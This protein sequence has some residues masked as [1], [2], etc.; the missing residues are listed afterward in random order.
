M[1]NRQKLS[2]LIY[3]TVFLI[4]TF[5]ILTNS[6]LSLSYA[7]TGLELWYRNMIPA[8]M[9]FMILSGTLIRMGLTEG[10]TTLVYPFVRPLFRV[11]RNV[12]Y[13]MIMGF[14]CGF[15]MG[16]KCVADLYERGKLSRD[17]G[18]YLLAFC[19]NIG[20]VYFVSFALPLIGCEQIAPCLFGMYGIPL[21]YGLVLRYTRY[22]KLSASP[23]PSAS[24]EAID[25]PLSVKSPAASAS[26]QKLLG[27]LDG[28]IRNSLQSMLMLGGYMVLFN[29][30]MLL[31]HLLLGQTPQRIAPLLEITGG[32]K[33]LG[34]RLPLYSL[35]VLPFGGFS[36]IAQ[37]YTCIGHT[38][39]S[40]GDYV[41]HKLMLTALT[42]GYYLLCLRFR[43]LR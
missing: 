22:R 1:H 30:L 3:I 29:L 18:A 31:P 27:A 28:S 38:D 14:M 26:S 34:N 4:L 41:L 15:P 43:L 32:L 2:D 10:F 37:T 8:L 7:F 39:L 17:E 36:C 42:A 5:C 33:L 35:I 9:P 21:L 20:P 40:I 13:V 25:A 23:E 19:N 24:P 11:S 12:C 6:R 16:A